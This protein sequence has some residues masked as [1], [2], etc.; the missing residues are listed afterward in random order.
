MLIQ[1]IKRILKRKYPSLYFAFSLPILNYLGKHLMDQRFPKVSKKN[2]AL[3]RW[4]LLH[5][6]GN[7]E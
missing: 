7:V 3:A 5:A 1:L 4:Y 2:K 6:Y